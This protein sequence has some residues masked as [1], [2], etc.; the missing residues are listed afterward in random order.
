MLISAKHP[1]VAPFTRRTDDKPVKDATELKDEPKSPEI[2]MQIVKLSDRTK[3][4]MAEQNIKNYNGAQ[5]VADNVDEA[6][7]KTRVTLQ[8]EDTSKALAS[9]DSTAVA[10][11]MEH[12]NKS[13][14]QRP[15][16]AI[17][18][19]LSL[20]EDELKLAKT[21][22]EDSSKKKPI[23]PVGENFHASI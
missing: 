1:P 5:I 12:M 23:D 13:L 4:V 8:A 11:L 18:E 21:G 15:R 10:D 20:T 17:S 9:S 19:E 2:Q 7:A 22:Q 3:A 16:P 6:F 14:E